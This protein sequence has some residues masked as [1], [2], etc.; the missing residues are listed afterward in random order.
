[1]ADTASPAASAPESDSDA[2]DRTSDQAVDS[3][4]RKIEAA[5]FKRLMALARPEA[6]TLVLATIALFIAAGLN[7]SYPVF[8]R[9]IIDGVSGEEA[10]QVVNQAAL[11]LLSLF[12]LNGLFTAARSYLFTVAGERVVTRLRSNL[13]R[14]L[15]SQEIAFFDERRTGELTNRLAADTTVLQNAATVNISMVLRYAATGLGAL[16]I[17]LYTSW[18]LTL[19]MLAVVPLVVLGAFAYGRVLRRISRKVQDALARSTEVAEETLSG[20]RTVRAFARED[21][22]GDRYAEH[23]EEVFNLARSRARLGAM[24]GGGMGFAFGGAVAVV[25]WYGGTMLVDG[26]MS[27]G[28][29]TQFVLYTFFVAMSLG[30]LSS[31]WEDFMK[32]MGASERVFQLLDRAPRIEPGGATI[33]GLRGEVS[34]AGVDFSYPSRSDV[35]VLQSL[36]LVLRPGETVA[37]VGP[38]G[39]GKSTVAALLSRFYDPDAGSISLDGQPY[40]ELDPAWL[41]R[42]VGVVSQEPV[43]FATTVR[44]NIRYGRPNA[45]DEDVEKAA[46]AANAHDFILEFPEGYET[47]VGERGVRLSGGQKQRVAI[48][49]AL[50]KDPRVLVLDEATSALDAESEHL[51]QEALDRLMVGRSTLVIAH[52]LS[53]VKDADRVLVLDHGRVVER[54]THLDLVAA[55]GLYRQLVERQFLATETAG[56]DVSADVTLPSTS[57]V[58]SKAAAVS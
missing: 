40:L 55:G 36:D 50:L 10:Q 43:L 54:G 22:E 33:D 6:K 25:L 23:A 31:V 56:V 37:L 32:A 48:A 3:K 29:L 9:Q 51:V 16:G 15:V 27:I 2:Y 14:S 12:A 7:L 47:L 45:S 42:Q 17:L 18:K 1:M 4:G 53:T 52:R 46:K 57:P 44:D 13:Y 19:V 28:E 41:R 38:S 20:I 35:P 11:V 5:S 58:P 24:F 30:A 49:R 26:D 21:A 8:I 34:I 39:G